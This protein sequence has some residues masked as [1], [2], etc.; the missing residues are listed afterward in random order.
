MIQDGG[1]FYVNPHIPG[2][3]LERH[4]VTYTKIIRYG[5][6]TKVTFQKSKMTEKKMAKFFLI[7]LMEQTLLDKAGS[8][9]LRVFG[10]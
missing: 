3:V 6:D 10:V 1:H 4:R 9:H 8:C 5:M 7:A 2:T